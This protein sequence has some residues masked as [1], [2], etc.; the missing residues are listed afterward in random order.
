MRP[1]KYQ[2]CLNRVEALQML[3]NDVS[4]GI[5]VPICE[6]NGILS[7]TRRGARNNKVRRVDM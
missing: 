6:E 1:S 2:F 5:L 7:E 3:D 4:G